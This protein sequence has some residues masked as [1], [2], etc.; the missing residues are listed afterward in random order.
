MIKGY[1]NMVGLTQFEM[2][3]KLG[4]SLSSYQAKEN[5]K[6]HFR[7]NEKQLFITFL[8]QK[9]IEVSIEEVFFKSNRQNNNINSVP[10]N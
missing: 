7:D 5:G 6:V 8:M 3:K 2:A 4:C 9:G 1:R 10:G